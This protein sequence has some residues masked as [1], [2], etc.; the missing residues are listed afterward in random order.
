MG[1]NLILNQAGFSLKLDF[2]KIKFQNMGTD[3]YNFKTVAYCQI[4]LKIGVKS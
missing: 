1:H 3:L 4:F 2:E